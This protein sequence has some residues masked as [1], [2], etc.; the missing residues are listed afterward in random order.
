MRTAKAH[1]DLDSR[2]PA[3]GSIGYSVQ[4][5]SYLKLYK[6]GTSNSVSW[7][8]AL[9][10]IARNDYNAAGGNIINSGTWYCSEDILTCTHA[11]THTHIYFY[12]VLNM[13]ARCGAFVMFC[14]VCWLA[15]FAIVI[16]SL[17]KRKRSDHFAFGWFI[18][19]ALLFFY[20][21]SWCHL[22]CIVDL[23]EHFP[24][25]H[26]ALKQRLFNVDS[27]FWH[28]INIESTL[29][30]RCVPAGFYIIFQSCMK[31]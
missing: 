8:S 22:F 18:T 6:I 14:L 12:G 23:Y 25:G 26:T 19:D 1:H 3:Y 24:S 11:R 16:T 17:G 5:E 30:Q 31:Y 2:A 20:S 21:S 4:A 29:F 15:L 13:A 7:R 10:R 28:W 9:G 27:M